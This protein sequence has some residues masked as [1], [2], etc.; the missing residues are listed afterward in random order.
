MKLPREILDELKCEQV[1][2]VSHERELE[3]FADRVYQVTK[4]AGG[5]H[6]RELT[7]P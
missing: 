4:E 7:A 6:I 3:S 2:M 5:S 1:I